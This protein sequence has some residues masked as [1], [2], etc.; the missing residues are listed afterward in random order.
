[1]IT[2]PPVEH[3]AFTQALETVYA[4]AQEKLPAAQQDTLDKA[5]EIARL[6]RVVMTGAHSANVLGSDGSTWYETNGRC[7]CP[8]AHHHPTLVCKH[9]LAVRLTQRARALMQA[10]PTP[11]ECW[12]PVD[13]DGT[14]CY[15][16]GVPC[17]HQ[18][19]TPQAATRGPLQAP[20]TERD[21]LLAEGYTEQELVE[22]KGVWTVKVMGLLRMVHSRYGI[23]RLDVRMDTLTESTALAHA[24]LVLKDGR[25]FSE[26]GISTPKNVGGGVQAHW[27]TMSLTRA[28]GRVCRNVLCEP[29]PSTEEM[30]E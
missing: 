9:R 14:P 24:T 4:S 28:K 20:R 27:Q 23:E 11:P 30:G 15:M 26:D 1:M 17:S 10:A 12:Q 7:T 22:I 18:D 3:N 8:A 6:G 5:L 19:T 2:V 29:A 25:T 16:A 13:T 21:R